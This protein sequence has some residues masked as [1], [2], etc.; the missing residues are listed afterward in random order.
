VKNSGATRSQWAPTSTPTSDAIILC[1]AVAN[2]EASGNSWLNG[3]SVALCFKNA[4]VAHPS[5]EEGKERFRNA[6][7][8]SISNGWMERGRRRL[9]GSEDEIAVLPPP[10]YNYS[11]KTDNAY[12]LEDYMRLTPEGMGLDDKNVATSTTSNLN[13]STHLFFTNFP[14][15]A[16]I[17]DFVSFLERKHHC[18]VLRASTQL[19]H[20]K[21]AFCFARVQVETPE[22]AM[23]LIRLASASDLVVQGRPLG[24]A[25]DKNV[26][27]KITGHPAHYYERKSHGKSNDAIRTTT[28]R[29]IAVS[30]EINGRIRPGSQQSDDAT[31]C[32]VL[33]QLRSG[34][35]HGSSGDWLP[36]GI[37][38]GK[39]KLRVSI[40]GDPGKERYRN[41]RDRA[42]DKGFKEMGRR[43]LNDQTTDREI[44][45]VPSFSPP[46][47]LS[48]L[49]PNGNL[50]TDPLLRLTGKGI[51]LAEESLAE[52]RTPGEV[53]VS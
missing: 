13:A 31:L 34:V 32:S 19:G 6:R 7:D 52:P 3:G 51:S 27:S 14:R 48:S 28:T 26:Q 21:A 35:A 46:T 23:K 42:I 1:K 40:P 9:G 41:A 5:N 49:W 43:K 45:V 36:A 25:Y 53:K 47:A 8:Q 38:G 16:T 37:V 44:V 30:S 2:Q 15:S 18:Q 50:S 11:K 4:V 24:A 20:P 10:D 33:Y 29:S 17:K 39:F 22:Q 12:S